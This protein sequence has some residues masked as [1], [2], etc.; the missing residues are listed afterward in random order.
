MFENKFIGK[1]KHANGED[2][3]TTGS[4]PSVNTCQEV[5]CTMESTKGTKDWGQKRK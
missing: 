1:N 5:A 3:Y 2:Y 4:W